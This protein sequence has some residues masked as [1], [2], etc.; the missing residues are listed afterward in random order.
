[1][2]LRWAWLVQGLVIGVTSG[3]ILA[4]FQA[5]ARKLARGRQR[6]SLETACRHWFRALRDEPRY[7][8]D[9][10]DGLLSTCESHLPYVGNY[11]KAEQ[12]ASFARAVATLK[13]EARIRRF[14]VAGHSH[15]HYSRLFSGFAKEVPFLRTRQRAH[16]PRR[17]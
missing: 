11:L 4:G 3:L 1:M 17:L 2:D 13:E 6:K 14:A 16:P 5:Q 9:V 7:W 15:D 8:G 12:A 10:A